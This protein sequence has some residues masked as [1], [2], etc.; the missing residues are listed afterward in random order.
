MYVG[1]GSWPA[2][3]MQWAMI[4]SFSAAALPLWVASEVS[5]TCR[6]SC[7]MTSARPCRGVSV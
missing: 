4:A 6:I 3:G 7:S 1:F 2:P 5:W